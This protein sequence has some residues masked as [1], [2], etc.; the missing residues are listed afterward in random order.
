MYAYFL[1][2]FAFLRPRV[3]I[4]YR[5]GFS[6]RVPYGCIPVCGFAYLTFFLFLIFLSLSP[7]PHSSSSA[8]CPDA[9]NAVASSWLPSE[10]RAPSTERW[11]P[12]VPTG[13]ADAP[14]SIGVLD[15]HPT[16]GRSLELHSRSV[17]TRP[18]SRIPRVCTL[19][20]AACSE[21]RSGDSRFSSPGSTIPAVFSREARTAARESTQAR[22]GGA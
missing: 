13:W 8:C 3:Y 6:G 17:P 16:H 10:R 14:G 19:S 7:P 2:F 20:P 4:V 1:I 9:A 22:G 11:H 21:T 12:G 5:S 18:C 15:P